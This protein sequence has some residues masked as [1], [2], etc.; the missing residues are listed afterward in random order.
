MAFSCRVVFL[1]AVGTS[2][3]VRGWFGYGCEIL[4]GSVVGY[5]CAQGGIDSG[6]EPVECLDVTESGGFF[7]FSAGSTAGGWWSLRIWI[8]PE[9]STSC[10]ICSSCAECG[11]YVYAF[12]LQPVR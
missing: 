9:C 5:A 1:T 7:C 3:S 2:F 8:L 12:E 4:K 11:E 10:F 6:A